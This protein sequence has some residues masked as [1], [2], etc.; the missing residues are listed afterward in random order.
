MKHTQTVAYA[1]S[2]LK[3]LG[4]KAELHAA[5]QTEKHLKL[6][7]P[8]QAELWKEIRLAIT[9]RKANAH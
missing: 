8:D 4:P 9:Q 6:N 5:Q 3:A 7:N 1:N 2:L